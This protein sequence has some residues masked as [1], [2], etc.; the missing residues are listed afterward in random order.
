MR[1]LM[2]ACLAVSFALSMTA[3]NSTPITS[4]QP[5]QTG[6]RTSF[7]AQNTGS[8]K[9]Q[10]VLPYRVQL[11]ARQAK[12]PDFSLLAYFAGQPAFA[13]EASPSPEASGANE[14]GPLT[15]EEIQA[16]TATVDG[17]QV[18]L[19]VTEITPQGEETVVDYEIDEA[20]VGEGLEVVEINTPTGESVGGAVVDA[21]P[22]STTETEITPE[23]TAVLETAC[24]VHGSQKIAWLTEAEMSA[25][26][27]LPSLLSKLASLRSMLRKDG[28][29]K[30][31]KQRIFKHKALNPQPTTSPSPSTS[32]N[33]SASPSSSPSP[34]PTAITS[35]SPQNCGCPNGHQAVSKKPTQS[36]SQSDDKG[37]NQNDERNKGKGQKGK[38]R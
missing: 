7:G 19:T 38:G 33:P 13:E 9:G 34:A 8:I 11:P 29:F 30:P 37:S 23:T 18:D 32:P 3:C 27:V 16:L 26:Q 21:E 36:K 5:L 1:K 35:S 24:D 20:P 12:A 25:L 10:L 14:A 15:A 31:N 4:T 22:G 2:N 17:Q 28:S 6:A